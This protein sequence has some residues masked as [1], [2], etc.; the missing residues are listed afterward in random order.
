MKDE[1]AKQI[2]FA[3]VFPKNANFCSEFYNPHHFHYPHS[4]SRDGLVV[5]QLH[6]AKID[7]K[8]TRFLLP[9]KKAFSLT[10]LSLHSAYL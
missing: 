8:H 9:K 4:S 7:T 10:A 5:S 6:K 1:D 2:D 3:A